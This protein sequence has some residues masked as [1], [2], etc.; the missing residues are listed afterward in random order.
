MSAS[1]DVAHGELHTPVLYQRVLHALR[2]SAGGRYIDGT[3]GTGGHSAGILETSSPNGHVL[4][5]DRDPAALAQAKSRLAHFGNRLHLRIGSFAELTKHAE[6]LGWATV[7][8]LLLD[9]GLS[10]MQL[11]DPARGF[12]F[13]LEGPLDMRF[14]PTQSL[15]AYDLVNDLPENELA[16]LIARFGEEPRANQVA[17]EIVRSRPLRNTLELSEAVTQ[18]VGRPR[19]RIHP[20]TRTFQALRIE[21]NGELEALEAGLAQAVDLLDPGGRLLVISFHSLEDRIVKQFF[22]D[23][24]KDCICPPQQPVCTC[25]HRARL[26]L[27]TRKPIRPDEAEIRANPRARSARLRIAERLELA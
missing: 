16:D 24:S 5:L 17:R 12:S 21:V 25:R 22:R 9:L 15:T 27:L 14:D 6:W 23:Q 4:G 11:N 3:I 2:P 7:D 13:R 1:E 20:A 19:R 26:H 18:A 8:G 10:S